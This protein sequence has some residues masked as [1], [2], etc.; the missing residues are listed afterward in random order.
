MDTFAHF[1]WTFALYFKR[2]QRLLASFIG[3]MP[4][5]ISFGPIFIYHL[6]INGFN[7][8][9]T[10]PKFLPEFVYVG[11]NFTHSIIIFF[12]IMGVIYFITREIPIILGGWLFHILIDI[13]THNNK[14]FPTPFLWPLSDFTV[15]GISW[16]D[17]VFMAVNYSLLFIILT[18]LF[19]KFSN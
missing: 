4:D 16:F 19:I 3:I 6:Y 1:L 13:P 18:Y 5:L 15:N 12:I 10:H 8:I 9:K 7:L 2:K 17:P 11:Y 14:F